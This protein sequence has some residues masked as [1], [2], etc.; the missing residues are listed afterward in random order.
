MPGNKT[1]QKNLVKN[2]KYIFISSGK[3]MQY[4]K[5]GRLATIV[6]FPYTKI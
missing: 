2:N 1:K 3:C 5:W 4:R 6:K